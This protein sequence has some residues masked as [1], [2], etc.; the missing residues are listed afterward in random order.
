ME[1]ARVELTRRG[2]ADPRHDLVAADDCGEHLAPSRARGLARSER[3]RTDDDADVRDRVRVRVVEVEAVAEH[4]V[5]EGRV[6]RGERAVEP[7]HRGLLEA[8][9]L[10]HRRTPLRRDAERVRRQAAA[11][12]V[13]QVQLRRLHHLGGDVLV[14]E[15][16][17]PLGEALRGLHETL[18][19]MSVPGNAGAASS[20]SRL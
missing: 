16:A 2:H 17:G 11:D 8:A 13:E 5:C 19:S 20:A 6:R 15:P 14:R 7:D 10:C 4:R 1:A 9:E 18:Q 3:C 12:R